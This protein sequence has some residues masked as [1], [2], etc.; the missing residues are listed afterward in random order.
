MKKKGTRLALFGIII[1]IAFGFLIRITQSYIK[2]E[3]VDLL[4]DEINTSTGCDFKYKSINV[5][6]LTLSAKGRELRIQCADRTKL[7][8]KRIYASFGLKDIFSKVIHLNSLDLIDGFSEDVGPESATYKFIDYLSAPLPPEKSNEDRLRLKLQRLTV[9]DSGFIEYLENGSL[10]GNKVSLLLHRDKNKDFALKPTIKTLKLIFNPDT[11]HEREIDLGTIT[12]SLVLLDDKILFKNLKL[13]QG[14]SFVN[15]EGISYNDQNHRLEGKAEYNI[16]NDLL[17]LPDWINALTVGEGEVFGTLSSPKVKGSIGLSKNHTAAIEVNDDKILKLN[18]GKAKILVDYNDGNPS[19]N[20]SK[21]SFSGE[22]TRLIFNKPVVYKDSKLSADFTLISDEVTHNDVTINGLNSKILLSDID[23]KTVPKIIGAIDA[24]YYGPTYIRDLEFSSDKQNEFISIKLKHDSDQHGKFDAAGVLVTDIVAPLKLK[25]VDISF[26]NF[27]PFQS[28]QEKTEVNKE[29]ILNSIRVSGTGNLSGPLNLNKFAGDANIKVVSRHFVGEAA[30]KGKASIKNGTFQVNVG[31]NSETFKLGLGVDLKGNELSKASIELSNFKAQEYNPE[32][33]CISLSLSSFYNFNALEALKGNGKL[34]LKSL[35]FGCEP[36]TVSLDKNVTIKINDGNLV[37]PDINLSGPET[38]IKTT[39]SISLE[40]GYNVR[41]D[42]AFLLS[43]FL[44]FFP[45]IDDLRGSTNATVFVSGNLDDP[46][47]EGSAK[48]NDGELS[49]E[50]ANI[51]GTEINGEVALNN[52]ILNLDGLSGRI[53]EGAFALSGAVDLLNITDSSV[54]LEFSDVLLEPDENTSFVVAGHAALTNSETGRSV[55]TGEVRITSG[56]FQKNLDLSALLKLL[57]EYLFRGTELKHRVSKLPN[58]LLDLDIV[59]DRNVFIFTNL[60]GTELKSNISVEGTLKEPIVNGTLESLSG[61]FGIKQRR[62][63]ITSG[64]IRFAPGLKQPQ[65][66]LLGETYVRARTG[67]SVLVILEAQGPLT[68]PRI[69]LSS[70]TGLSQKELLALV[71]GAGTSG[72]QTFRSEFEEE[73]RASSQLSTGDDDIQ[74]LTKIL[75]TLTTIDSI[76]LE[77]DFNI[78]RGLIEPS[79]IA[80]KRIS[81]RMYL[82]GQTFLS[83]TGNESNLRLVYNLFPLISIAGIVDTISSEENTALGADLTFTII[84][85]QKKF[86]NLSFQGNSKFSDS[87]LKRKL[88][89]SEDSRIPIEDLESIR[90]EIIGLYRSEGYFQV[91]VETVAIDDGYFYRD[92]NFNIVENKESL[93]SDIVI[94]DGR[95]P[96]EIKIG[97]L[98]DLKKPQTA[99]K[100]FTDSIQAELLKKLRNEGYIS[101]RVT[102]E[103]LPLIKRNELLL[104]LKVI[105]GK[106]VSFTFIGNK[107]FSSEEFLST[108]NLFTRKQPFGNNTILILIENIERMYRE[109][110]YLFSSLSY[111]KDDKSDPNRILFTIY[112]REE[113]KVYVSDVL[114]KG[115][116]SFS[117]EELLEKISKYTAKEI[118]SIISP[119]YAIAEELDENKLVIKELLIDEGFA[120]AKVDY[121]LVPDEKSNKVTIQY[122]ITEGERLYADWIVVE[123]LPEEVEAPNKPLSPYSI[124]KGNRYINELAVTLQNYGYLDSNLWSNIDSETGQLV[125]HVETGER[126]KIN[127]IEISGLNRIK[128]KVIRR[129]ITVKAGDPWNKEEL[130]KSKRSLLKLGLFSR[131]SLLPADGK[132]DS[133]EETLRIHVVERA[134]YSLELGGGAN[135]E[136]GAH[137]FGEATDRA[138]IGDGKSLTLRADLYY[139]PR[140]SDISQGAATF[141]YTDPFVFDSD[142]TLTEDLRFQKLDLSTYEFDLDR[143]SLAS[144]FSRSWDSGLAFSLGH[145]IFEESLENVSPDAILGPLDT[146]T[147]DLSFLSGRFTYDR[148]DNPLNPQSGYSVS[149]DYQFSSEAIL[150][151]ANFYSTGVRISTVRP[152]SNF[153]RFSL[154]ASSRAA[155]AWTFGETDSIP[156]SERYY[157]GGR[158]SVR[159]FRENSLGPRGVMGSVIGGDTYIV[160]NIELRYRLTDTVAL[161]TFFDSGSVF[162]RDQSFSIDD[163]RTSTGTGVRYLSPIGPIGIDIGVPIDERSGEPSF[164][165]H[166]SIGS[167]F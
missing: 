64:V 42:G 96:S 126:T 153:S 3:L 135:S 25:N 85:G 37:L 68:N 141:R 108:I 20:I 14:S 28:P 11:I 127:N 155:A 118:S 167:N 107:I 130:R 31:N 124:P 23:G 70:D 134:L 58:I 122:N 106:P 123:D 55:L 4:Q 158:N 129:I 128:E 114:F 99:T 19:L 26:K 43:P 15:A 69:E 27:R 149:L 144:Y 56:E 2:S 38:T 81:D 113:Q 8:F 63:E 115:I 17:L 52:Q 148:R 145:T 111:E 121:V 72:G 110:G 57:T 116:N 91:K 36:H 109:A 29:P 101:A 10:I 140:I 104:S 100:S 21:S 82:L 94:S 80:T 40:K 88:R 117:E 146:G 105:P 143:I 48:L 86:I 33:E 154:A 60:I 119:R 61:W 120:D 160:N 133:N 137:I 164:R 53:N 162:L 166:F 67:E 34:D 151:D 161:H 45:E 12:A 92:I 1:G 87:T 13:V 59:A 65:L 6:L 9:T 89:L 150:S 102:T 71:S 35:Q 24:I 50:L 44:T 49:S 90:Q 98:L 131:V 18:S 84:T 139:D 78:R 138:T 47:F 7:E 95:I 5:S 66:E 159:G 136:L 157:A 30:L 77:P 46:V 83:G 97:K 152:F 147:V 93:V 73:L 74:G 22:L 132:L 165:V 163:F 142:F 39:G 125:V 76:S 112:I 103:Y 16:A 41:V 79:L 54:A 156:I 32:L 62:F 51:S 75:K